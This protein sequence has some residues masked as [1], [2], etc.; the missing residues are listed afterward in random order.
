MPYVGID[1][2]QCVLLSGGT[3]YMLLKFGKHSF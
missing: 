1:V 2:V 3:L